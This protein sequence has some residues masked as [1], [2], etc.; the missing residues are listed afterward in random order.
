MKMDKLGRNYKIYS[1]GNQD[2]VGIVGNK[3]NGPAPKLIKDKEWLSID[4]KK[5]WD[6]PIKR[7]PYST[8]AHF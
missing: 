2:S 5:A 6:Q 7:S 3:H 4:L 1:V 8:N